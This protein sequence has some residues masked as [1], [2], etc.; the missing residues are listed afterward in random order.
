MRWSLP[1]EIGKCE[2]LK[3]IDL[4]RNHFRGELLIDHFSNMQYLEHLNISDNVRI[5]G[6][7]PRSLRQ[8]HQSFHVTMHMLN[9]HAKRIIRNNRISFLF[10]STIHG[11]VSYVRSSFWMRL[12]RDLKAS[13]SSL[14]RCTMARALQTRKSG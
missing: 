2:A 6:R 9:G 1:P 8:V 13:T 11:T 14:L 3:I 4:S 7:L 5:S 12:L 10:S